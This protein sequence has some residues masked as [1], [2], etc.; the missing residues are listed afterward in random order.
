MVHIGIKTLLANGLTTFFIKGEP[1]F[2]N[3]PKSL[4]KYPSD[5]PILYN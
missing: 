2:S 3:G 1:R 4:P 5:C